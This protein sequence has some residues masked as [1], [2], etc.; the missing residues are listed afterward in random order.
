MRDIKNNKKVK[1]IEVSDDR[2]ISELLQLMENTGFQG[3]SLGKTVSIL[4]SY[5]SPLVNEI[6]ILGTNGYFTVRDGKNIIYSPRDTFD[7]RGY[8]TDP[9]KISEEQFNID[10]DVSNSLRSSMEYFIEQV[11]N[12]NKIEP[13]FFEASIETN[14]AILKLKDNPEIIF[15]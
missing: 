2:T 7:E 14:Q 4:N 5:A 12:N 1:A 3:K 15:E 9:P 10:D 11:K 6:S 13:K 8:F